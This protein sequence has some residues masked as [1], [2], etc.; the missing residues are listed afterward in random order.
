MANPQK[1]DGY[2]AIANEIM[3]ALCK[4]RIPGE[5]RQVLDAILRKTYG[6]NKCEDAISLSQ[7]VEMTGLKKPHIVR[8]IKN[9]ILKNVI[10]KKDNEN[11]S[12]YRFNKDFDHWQPLS[13]KITTFKRESTLKRFCYLCGFSEALEE[14]HIKP[15]FH[16]GSNR[17]ENKIVLCPNCH[18]LT[19]K[20]KYTE[21]ELIAKKDNVESVASKD[22]DQSEK[23]KTSLSKKIPTKDT[24]TKDT[25]TKDIYPPEFLTFWKA[26]PKKVGKDAALKAWKK[27]NGTRPGI[28]AI[29]KAIEEQKR[30]DQWTRDSGQYIPNPATWINQGR[31]DDEVE[32][33]PKGKW[34]SM[35]DDADA[36]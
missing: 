29:I 11:I 17:I 26:Y 33:Q 14:H 18:T 7:F 28:D 21:E 34:E 36:L 30:S 9:L 15:I 13:K 1:E 12:T 20:G 24:T 4:I 25:L 16:G 8:A 31:W 22:N 10:I 23:V 19:H 6:W 27:R 5:E 3:D 2:T 35:T 32:T